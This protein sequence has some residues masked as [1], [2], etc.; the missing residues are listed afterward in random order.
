MPCMY[1]A[2]DVA[3]QMI[4]DAQNA[5]DEPMQPSSTSIPIVQIN[6]YSSDTDDN[7]DQHTA[8]EPNV[9]NLV[10]GLEDLNLNNLDPHVEGPAHPVFRGIYSS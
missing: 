5:P 3:V 2:E 1:S 9:D 6:D 7:P 8:P 10:P 4:Y